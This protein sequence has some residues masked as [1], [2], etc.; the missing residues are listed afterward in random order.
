MAGDVR[1]LGTM[2]VHHAVMR[3]AEAFM[4][5]AGGVISG[6]FGTAGVVTAGVE[7]GEAAD[8]VISSKSAIGSF[9]EKGFVQGEAHDLGKVRIAIGVAIG[10]AKPD[11]STIPALTKTLSEVAGVAFGDPNGGATSGIH[12]AKVLDRL[13]LA[14]AVMKNAILRS[15]GFTV[16]AEVAAGRAPFGFT[17]ASEIM[18]SPGVEIAGYLPDEL[19]LVS[20]YTAALTP[21]GA[22]NDAAK[23]FLLRLTGPDAKQILRAEGLE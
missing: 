17:Q 1:I 9:A 3:I 22:G 23:A 11:I 13:G 10:G 19:Q 7:S 2:A 16:M 12:F 18:A 15:N 21:Q 4:A 6:S 14:E 8:I 5:D 20:T